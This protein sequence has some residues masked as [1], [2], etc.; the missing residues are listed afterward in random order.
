MA[1]ARGHGRT[2]ERLIRQAR[3]EFDKGDPLQ[4]SEKA[5]G[6]VA[7]YVKG[8][9]RKRGKRLRS[10]E[11]VVKMAERLAEFTDDPKK[12][13]RR[14][15]SVTALHRNFYEN[16]A[17]LESVEEGIEDAAEL[18]A[19][20][21]RA[22]P[23]FPES[24]RSSPQSRKPRKS[25]QQ[26]RMDELKRKYAPKKTRSRRDDPSVMTQAQLDRLLP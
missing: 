16:E 5:W 1:N 11:S 19:A 22:E 4:A 12:Q 20:L 17:G 9:A 21:K 6:S 15:R 18:I 7:H 23:D 26:R 10:H 2:S 13:R 24:L 8:A 25:E 3:E 14:F